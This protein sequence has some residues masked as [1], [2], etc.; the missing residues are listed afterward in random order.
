MAQP[1]YSAADSNK[2]DTLWQ[3]MQERWT[4]VKKI[5]K[6][7]GMIVKEGYQCLMHGQGED[8]TPEKGK[9]LRVMQSFLKGDFKSFIDGAEVVFRAHITQVAS[10]MHLMGVKVGNNFESIKEGIESLASKGV[11]PILKAYGTV[12]KK[13]EK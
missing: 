6:D 4:G 2:K 5:G 1:V 10:I 13:F 11:G 12:R 7:V 9:V 8:C 3:K